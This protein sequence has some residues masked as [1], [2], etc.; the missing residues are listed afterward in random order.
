MGES[1]SGNI[2]YS[3]GV[4]LINLVRGYAA[5]IIKIPKNKA[6]EL[7]PGLVGKSGSTIQ[8]KRGIRNNVPILAREFETPI[9]KERLLIN[10]LFNIVFK[11]NQLPKPCPNAIIK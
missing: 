3:S 6:V 5:N 7:Q 8:A 9:A 10:Q 1:P 11:A 4:F 2:P